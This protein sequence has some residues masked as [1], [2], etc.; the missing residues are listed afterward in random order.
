MWRLNPNDFAQFRGGGGQRFAHFVDRLIRATADRGGLPQSEIQTQLRVNIKDGGVDTQVKAA[1]PEDSSGWFSA[2]TCWQFKSVEAGDINDKE[3]K[4]KRN[5]LQVEINKPF[6]RELIQQGYAYRL[7]IL[8]DLAPPKVDKWERQLRV[9][10]DRINA[11]A[12][13]PCVLHG[14]SL[15]HWGE[16]FPAIVAWVRNMTQDLLHWE[17]WEQICREVTRKYV[18]N[19][20]WNDHQT[21]IRQHADL[22]IAPI[23]GEPC[24]TIGGAAGV[25]KT[26]L[27]FE[28]LN[29]SEASPGLVV[30]AL[31]EREVK[32]LAI[33]VVNDPG[34][35]AIV[36]ADECTPATRDFLNELGRSYVDR[37]RV[38]CVDNSGERLASKASPIRLAPEESLKNSEPILEANFPAVPRDRRHQYAQLA[39]GFVRLA[40]DMCKHDLELAGG[41]MSG[42]L[43]SVERYVRHRVRNEHLPLLSLLALFHKVGFRDD[44]RD[45]LQTLCQIANCTPQEFRDVVQEVRESP[46]FVVQAGRYWYVTPEI[47]ARVLFAVGWTKW[48]QDDPAEFMQGL[49]EAFQQQLIDRAGK[50]GEKEVRDELASFFRGWFTRLNAADLGQPNTANLVAA[51]VEANPEQFLPLLRSIIE[52]ASGD[53]LLAISGR[54]RNG[55]WGPRRTLVW[56]FEKLVSFPDFFTD[57]EAGLFHLAVHE[58]EPRTGNNAT[59]IWQELFSVYL[60]GTATPFL[61]RLPMLRARVESRNLQRAKLAFR[62]VAKALTQNTAKLVGAPIVAGRLRP[63][64]WQP[65]S[66]AEEFVCYEAALMLCEQQLTQGDASR[67]RMAFDVLVSSIQFLLHKGILDSIARM[68]RP[69]SLESDEART[70]VNAVDGFIELHRKR[71]WERPDNGNPS[72]LQRV[73]DWIDAFR[74]SDFDGRLRSV[75][76]REPW[77]DRFSDDPRTKRDEIDG[78][79]AQIIQDEVLLQ[80]HLDW[81]ATPE[82]Q[83]AERLG[84]AIARADEISSCLET[85]FDHAIATGAVPLLRGY[86][87]G[88]AF[89]ERPPPAQLNFLLDRL[90]AAH[91]NS[92]IDILVYGGDRFDAL[93]RAIRLVERGAVSPQYLAGFAMGF[94]RRELA[95]EEAGR[96]IPVF[97]EAARAG[98]AASTQAGVRFLSAIR[99]FEDR[100]ARNNSLDLEAVRSSAWNLIELSLPLIGSQLAVDWADLVR[101]L[102]S[103]DPQRAVNLLGNAMLSEDHTVV[104]QAEDKLTALAAKYPVAVMQ[105]FGSALLHPDQG[106]RLQVAVHRDLVSQLPS[107]VVLDWVRSN[108]VN[109]ARAIARHLP[110]PYLDESSTPVVPE[111]LDTF[112]RDYNDNEVLENFI[113]GVHSIETWAGNNAEQFRRQAEDARQFLNHP[114]KQIRQWANC[115]IGDRQQMAEWEEQR[116]AERFLPS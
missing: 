101:E 76:S 59:A 58:T 11:S 114:N 19:S 116:H 60:S 25:G 31:D 81:L 61:D 70:L 22:S 54:A 26:R 9:E 57:C 91:P 74:P 64:Q 98:D 100:Q 77:D 27:V 79:A 63:R 87:R 89:A 96:L 103:F 68:F 110:P 30:Y 99:H 17:A 94:G 28:T 67:R 41:D 33:S 35:A 36:V 86:V 56:L 102:A 71:R 44:A 15:L 52:N 53:D 13:D 38:I 3:Y 29:D 112:L 4:K 21:Q 1:I 75:C 32:S 109:A 24:L 65:N 50:L 90:E 48:V 47:V 106:W 7:C 6:A 105:A 85:V 16:R 115:E 80:P 39:Q 51:L 108:G 23:D 88:M 43:G 104:G 40:A 46:G 18:P 5:D 8:G 42:L 34:Q 113:S 37:L 66:A 93:N 12:P 10:A 20:A 62:G 14:G 69:Q 95:S 2:P 72:Y 82:A 49:P 73:S 107:T 78:L 83:S 45:E 97:I 111:M 55:K 84:F 92:A